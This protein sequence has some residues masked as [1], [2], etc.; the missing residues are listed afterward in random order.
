[1]GV[2]GYYR[3]TTPQ[4]NAILSNG[5]GSIIRNVKA[6]CGESACGL[7]SLASSRYIHD[8]PDRPFTIH[9]ALK[10]NGYTTHMILGGDHT[11]FYNLRDKYGSV[12]S[13]FDGSMAKDFYMNDDSFLIKK[14]NELPQWDS[15]PVSIQYHLMST[16][17]LGL[18][19]KAYNQFLPFRKYDA[20]TNEPPNIAFTNNYDN[21]VLQ[22]D[23]IIGS[24]LKS[25]KSKGYLENSLVVITGDHGDGLGEHGKYSHGNS[26]YDELLNIPLIFISYGSS[27][28]IKFNVKNL[29]SQIDIAPSILQELNIEVPATWS[30]IPI[31]SNKSHDLVHFQMNADFGVYDHRDNNHLWKYWKNLNSNE[32]FVFNLSTDP[33]EKENLF[34]RIPYD[35]KEKFFRSI[36]TSYTSTIF[37]PIPREF[38]QIKNQ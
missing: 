35:Q 5:Q 19:H 6:S 13:F 36:V 12:D 14:T 10:A 15:K 25:L 37:V 38:K 32:F 22:M 23:A 31:Q 17:V 8:F 1:M 4:L 27:Q 30:G 26:V 20:L 28:P 18:H 11:N 21:G 2:Y 3:D 7:T 33:D 9:Q 29:I 16:H 34:D 24:L